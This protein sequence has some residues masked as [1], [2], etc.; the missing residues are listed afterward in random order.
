MKEHSYKWILLCCVLLLV[1]AHF[2]VSQEPPP[3]S[4]QPPANVAGKWT[5]YA[6]DPKGGTSTKYIELQQDGGT[7]K[8]HFKGPNQSGGLEGTIQE[9]HIV[10]KTKTRQVLVFRGRVEGENVNGVI[11]GTKIAGNFHAPKGTGTWEAVRAN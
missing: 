1:V 7:L 6:K 10:F 8:G 5:I 4:G 3:P 9:R 2:G 11:Q